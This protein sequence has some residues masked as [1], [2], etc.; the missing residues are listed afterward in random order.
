MSQGSFSPKIRFL[1][2]K[3]CSVVRVQTH[4]QTRK[5]ILRAPFQ[6]FRI[7]S[8]NLSSRIGPIISQRTT[9]HPDKSRHI[10][11]LTSISGPYLESKILTITSIKLEILFRCRSLAVKGR[12][13]GSGYLCVNSGRPVCDKPSITTPTTITRITKHAVKGVRVGICWIWEAGQL[14]N[15][16]QQGISPPNSHE[17]CLTIFLNCDI[18]LLKY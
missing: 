11:G 7:F 10:S 15:A 14:V 17:S 8:F 18:R 1:Y 9:R 12:A 2:Q 4:R 6:G 5:W 3:V 16:G 13:A